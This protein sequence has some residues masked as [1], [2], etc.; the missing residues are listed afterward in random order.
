MRRWVVIAGSDTAVPLGSTLGFDFV[1]LVAS[2]K[3]CS[4]NR[5]FWKTGLALKF[6]CLDNLQRWSRA[7]DS[8]VSVPP[9]A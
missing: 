6:N 7:G 9:N 4:G 5:R 3:V 1:K 8:G 2:Q